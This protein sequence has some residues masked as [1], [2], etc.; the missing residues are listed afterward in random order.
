MTTTLY[1][2][3]YDLQKLRIYLYYNR[4]F[5]TPYVLDVKKELDKTTDYRK[6][7][8]KDLISYMD[9]NKVKTQ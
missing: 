7:S 3:I 5:D 9:M 6:I 2:V 4:Q 1:S 8:L